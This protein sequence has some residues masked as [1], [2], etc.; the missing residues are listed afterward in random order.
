MK[1]NEFYVYIYLDPRK[2]GDYMYGD[3]KF[4][5]EPFYVG[6][7]KD[8]RMY[9]HNY[10]FKDDVNS[11][12]IGKIKKII[13]EKKKPI[14]E[15]IYD[16]LNE[17]D[18]FE[19]EKEVIFKIGR[20]KKGPL[21]NFSDGG[22]GQSG[23]KHREETK[24]KI[25][26][27]VKNSEKW[28][29]SIKSDEHKKNLSD[30]LMGH[31]GWNKGGVRSEED[32]IKIKEG[33]KKSD[34]KCGVIKHSDESKKKMS[35]KRKGI[36]NSNSVTYRIKIPNKDIIEFTGKN[37][38]RNYINIINKELKYHDR[39][40]LEKLIKIGEIKNYIIL[41]KTKIHKKRLNK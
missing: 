33:L 24:K 19:K 31:P 25:G 39:I 20:L 29:K 26:E 22:E 11:Y 41:S 28:Q 27:G 36:D 10:L 5:Y 12:K 7:G 15:K 23:Y 1:K 18:S 6:K 8:D 16:N 4:D 17:I 14:I 2:P 32:R 38:L 35:E 21:V 34:K 13:S 3:L 40:N 30:A 37:K 9:R